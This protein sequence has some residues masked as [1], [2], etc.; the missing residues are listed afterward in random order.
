MRKP[1]SK[2][3]QSFIESA[4]E[5][6]FLQQQSA[7]TAAASGGWRYLRWLPSIRAGGPDLFVADDVLHLLDARV[8]PDVVEVRQL[9]VLR[10]SIYFTS[11]TRTKHC[12]LLV[13]NWSYEMD[14]QVVFHVIRSTIR[15]PEWLL[16]NSS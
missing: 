14:D 13:S 5:M 16:I 10:D 4:L 1:E 8:N 6:M 7:T 3:K 15:I 2:E 9:E 12:K 11:A